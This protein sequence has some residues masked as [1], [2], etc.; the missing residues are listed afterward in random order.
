MAKRR[1]SV[2]RRTVGRR[3]LATGA[4]LAVALVVP[5]FLLAYAA[6]ARH[7]LST[8]LLRS[9]V[10]TPST[11]IDYDE[12]TSLWPGRLRIRN[13]RIRA[14][15]GNAQWALR[16]EEAHVA[17]SL[18]NLFSKTFHVLG[19]RGS[20]LS[21][22]LRQLRGPGR[23]TTAPLSVLPDIP[24]FPRDPVS[25]VPPNAGRARP[26]AWAVRVENIS[27]DRLD[28]IWLDTYR[29]RGSARL[30]GGFYLAPGREAEVGPA[31]I[32]FLSGDV[33]IGD[34]PVLVTRRGRIA[35]RIARY[36]IPENP[37][38]RVWKFIS[39]SVD[40]HGG[41]AGLHFLDYFLRT[42]PEPRFSGGP[43]TL[44]IQGH[45][46]KGL[47]SGEV[48]LVS[49][50]LRFRTAAAQVE[51]DTDFL[52]RIRGWNLERGGLDV[53]GSRLAVSKLGSPS[54]A[55]SGWSGSF[56]VPHGRIDGPMDLRFDAKCRDAKPLL[57]LLGIRPP[58]IVRKPL[59]L[60]D[61]TLSASLV[62]GS[63]L[64]RV[65]NLDAKGGSI[66]VTGE[67]R[68]QGAREDG[69]FLIDAGKI[70]VGVS[71]HG[72]TMHLRPIGTR[73]WLENERATTFRDEPAAQ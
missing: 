18:T 57:S 5:L 20:G 54:D 55:E 43:G 14:D 44:A 28:E 64:V 63:S 26:S 29:S 47:G 73:G 7:F 40:L 10:S 25:T 72:G 8:P 65:R 19:I 49:H 41:T 27:I 32:D 50:R 39:G 12:A 22:R 24:G 56:D 30:T 1:V 33:R 36:D 13:L 23:P 46:E 71:L 38:D 4:I 66:H 51:T 70:N 62:L 60:E 61:L 31:A 37:G 34:D 2:R 3:R 42:S 6:A 11:Q 16:L 21:F 68:K 35:G 53:S 48:R 67:Y 45:V 59:A 69:A 9:L 15:D 52:L 17:F 58:K